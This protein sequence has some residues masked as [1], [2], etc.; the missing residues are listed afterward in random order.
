MAY[1]ISLPIDELTDDVLLVMFDCYVHEA[2]YFGKINEWHLL[3]HESENGDGLYLIH[4][5]A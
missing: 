2:L 3:V 4:R 5:I 1:R